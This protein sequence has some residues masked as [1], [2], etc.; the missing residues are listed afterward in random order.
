M[1]GPFTS[2]TLEQHTQAQA[3][4]M[5]NGK[6]W[7]AKNIQSSKTRA[8]LRGLAASAKR[9]EA[10]LIDFWNEVFIGTAYDFVPDF[11][12]AL[13][14]PDHCFDGTGTIEER[15]TDCQIK[16]VSLYVVTEQDFI[17]LALLLG[18]VI[19]IER[20]VD[21]TAFP[22]YDVPFIPVDLKTARFTW[23]VKGVD[24][25]TGYPPYDVPFIPGTSTN[26]EK[27]ICLFNKLKPACTTII[28]ENA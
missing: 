20:P 24:L 8:L 4:Y 26:A 22:P 9:L 19:T 14:I 25:V 18:Y 12:R 27:L 13:G 11:E 16:L 2:H 15:R 17:D 21:T 7:R 1:A 23:I 6:A 3:D 10:T 28:Y 5:H